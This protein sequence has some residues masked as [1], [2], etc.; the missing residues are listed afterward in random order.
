MPMV[1]GP[2]L[3]FFREKVASRFSSV[4]KSSSTKS[5]TSISKPPKAYRMSGHDKSIRRL[6]SNASDR[7]IE[8]NDH[9][10][11][12]GGIEKTTVTSVYTLP[13]IPSNDDE[14]LVDYRRGQVCKS[15]WD[16]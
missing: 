2:L 10:G 14:R 11:R 7:D 8:M 6:P 16:D 9:V 13:P 5:T 1:A 12:Y 3:Y 15:Q 4:A